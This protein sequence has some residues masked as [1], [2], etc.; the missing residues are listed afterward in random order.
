[1]GAGR[2]RVLCKA[3]PAVAYYADSNPDLSADA[4][5]AIGQVLADLA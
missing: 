2:A 4:R 1:M 3:I 5:F